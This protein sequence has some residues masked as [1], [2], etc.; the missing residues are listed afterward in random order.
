MG[1][2]S[3]EEIIFPEGLLSIEFNAFNYCTSLKRVT[4]PN[5]VKRLDPYSFEGC[6][7]LEEFNLPNSIEEF[8]L[9]VVRDCINLKTLIIP[10]NV[11]KIYYDGYNNIQTIYTGEAASHDMLDVVEFEFAGMQDGKYKFVRKG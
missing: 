6:H 7:S 4:I 10:D 3:L 8:C 5:T 2:I 9:S 1:C 11:K